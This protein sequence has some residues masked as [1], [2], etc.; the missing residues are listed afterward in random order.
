MAPLVSCT[1][2]E[3][4]PGSRPGATGALIKSDGSYGD[5]T[6]VLR[7][8]HGPLTVSELDSP[9]LPDSLIANVISSLPLHLSLHM[10]LSLPASTCVAWTQSFHCILSKLLSNGESQTAIKLFLQ[11]S[12]HLQ[13]RIGSETLDLFI[14][15]LVGIRRTDLGLKLYME[16]YNLC[17]FPSQ[18]TCQVLLKGLVEVGMLDEAMHLLYSMMREYNIDA[19]VVSCRTIIEELCMNGRAR[20][21]EM[22]LKKVLLKVRRRT[23]RVRSFLR[24]PINLTGKSLEEVRETVD[25]ILSVSGARSVAAYEVIAGDLFEERRF[26]AARKVFDEM[27]SK[28]FQPSVKM[29]EAKIAALCREGMTDDAF[30]VLEEE[31]RGK[32][33]AP[34]ITIFN[35]LIKGLCKGGQSMKAVGYLKIMSRWPGC[36][37]GKE[38]FEILI[39]GLCAEKRYVKAGDILDEM[40]KQGH[41]P[42]NDAFVSVVH[43]LCEVRTRYEALLWLEEMIAHGV[44]PDCDLWNSLISLVCGNDVG[45]SSSLLEVFEDLNGTLL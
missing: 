31:M 18:N 44:L 36:M 4:H 3:V 13:V 11:F 17:C 24:V 45:S 37:A 42:K 43:G 27:S 15:Y 28:G 2:P 22:V 8:T 12:R 29:F 26:Q 41:R 39:D 30:Q 21:G 33:I 32:D 40:V 10:F 14:S 6:N 7:G 23:G 35:L 25:M 16:Y 5:S 1:T 9:P 20:E 19:I 34:T 38:T